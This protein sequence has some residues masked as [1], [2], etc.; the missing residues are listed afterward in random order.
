MI[1]VLSYNGDVATNEV[2]DWLHYFRCDYKRINLS[3][4]DYKKISLEIHDDECK[5]QL[6]LHN[7]DILDVNEVSFFLYRGGQFVFDTKS[8]YSKQLPHA[9]AA[10]HQKYEFETLTKFFYKEVS[11]KCLGNPLYN[12]LNKLEQLKLAGELGIKVPNT[13]IGSSKSQF[14]NS[15]LKDQQSY[16]TKSIQENILNGSQS[17]GY[18]LKVNQVHA[19]ELE[20][21]FFPSLFQE[22]LEKSI[23]IR[24]FYL[25]GKFYSIGMLTSANETCD[26]DFR[27][28]IGNLRYCKYTLPDMVENKLHQLMLSLGLNTGSI[29]LILTNNGEYIFLEVNQ[30][31]QFGW[32]SDFGNYYIER[33]IAQ[34]LTKKEIEYAKYKRCKSRAC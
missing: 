8:C 18:D 31:G 4:E 25:N 24:S 15:I 20:E 14:Y 9:I 23:E 3:D 21:Y 16:I 30:T 27:S 6:Q 7:D 32:V 17:T 29:D 19:S 34:F 1:V 22:N 13:F 10:A 11:K 2:M 33:E 26:V 5:L 12:P 28:S